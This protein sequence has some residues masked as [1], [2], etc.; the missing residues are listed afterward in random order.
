MSEKYGK[1]LKSDT[2][3]TKNSGGAAR[4]RWRGRAC[5]TFLKQLYRL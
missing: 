4:A 2:A 1:A 3:D 5:S